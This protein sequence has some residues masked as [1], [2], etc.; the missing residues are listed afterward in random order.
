MMKK[1]Y[2]RCIPF[3]LDSKDINKTSFYFHINDN[4]KVIES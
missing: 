2:V 1:E 4:E 3:L